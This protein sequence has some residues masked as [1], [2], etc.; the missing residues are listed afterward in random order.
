MDRRVL[1]HGTD[2]YAYRFVGASLELLYDSLSVQNSDA[3]DATLRYLASTR[4]D[5]LVLDCRDNKMDATPVLV[6]SVRVIAPA[7]PLIAATRYCA[8]SRA[9][10]RPTL[11]RCL[12]I[13]RSMSHCTNWRGRLGSW[14]SLPLRREFSVAC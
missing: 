8:A 4:W 11:C 7:L 13:S 5:L 2:D 10:T 9:C 3:L 1:Y 14:C 12:E 6:R